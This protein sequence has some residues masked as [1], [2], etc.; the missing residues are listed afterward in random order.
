[1][2]LSLQW[3]SDFVA[4]REFDAHKI[5]ERLT[6]GTAEVEQIEQQGSLLAHCVVGKVLTVEKHPNADSLLLCDVKT[7]QGIKRIVCGGTNLEKDMLVAFAHVGA[8]VRWHGEAVQELKVT[9]IR[10]EKSEGMICAAEE[11]DLQ[12]LLPPKPEDGERPIVNL[13]RLLKEGEKSVGQ[14]LQKVLERTDTIFHINNTAITNR[15]DLFSHVGFARECVVLGLG[16]WKKKPE[17]IL[18]KFP[19]QKST[20]R[21]HADAPELAT[22]YLGCMLKVTGLGVTPDWMRMRLEAV[23][24][25]SLNLAVDITNYVAQE[26]G[27]PLHSFDADDIQGEVHMRL[28]RKGEIITTLD[29]VERKLPEGALILSDD[30]GVFDLLGIMGGLRSS[31]KE[32]T[33]NIFLHAASLN[34]AVIRRTVL[35]TGHRTDASTVYEKGVPPVVTSQG[36]ARA[37]GLFLE[38]LPGAEVASELESFG[39]DGTPKIITLSPKKVS[40]HLGQETSE[41]EISS[42]LETLGFIV[43][44]GKGEELE[45]STPLHRLGDIHESADLIE[46]VA[47]IAGLEGY[48]PELPLASITLPVRDHRL[49]LLRK[50]LKELGCTELVQLTFVGEN[51]LKQVGVPVKDL[52]AVQNPL[53]EDVK[54]IR[55]SLLPRLLEAANLNREHAE[56]T[57][58]LFEIGHVVLNGQEETE[59]TLLIVEKEKKGLTKEP[60]LH[61]KALL[62]E[63]AHALGV[64]LQFPREKT[65]DPKKHP[66]RNAEILYEKKHTGELFELHPVISK[67]FGFPARAAVATLS[68]DV[69]LQKK[70]QEKVYHAVPSFPSIVYDTTISVDDAVEVESLLKK[71]SG[72][73]PLLLDI[74]LVD[75]FQK[76]TKERKLTFRCTYNAPDRTLREDEVKPVHERV[77]QTLKSI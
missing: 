36:F 8:K 3:L 70:A 25:R 13:G 67:H 51:L 74:R 58:Q 68:P 44:R 41:E 26:V 22:R 9:K 38:L 19:S 71:T 30:K 72:M 64:A 77:E 63:L 75:L 1:M 60:F 45:V 7:E 28:S 65:S 48:S 56:A 76:G 62:R 21:I 73:H 10:G 40:A 42:P 53:G 4:F 59:L 27:V 52:A 66:A 18:P 39:S 69:L 43:K 17:W 50:T 11:L 5:A 57:L 33:K 23:G 12:S 15:P 47:R 20:I 55:P 32:S 31:T 2:K 46:E 14:P 6:L 16:T 49:T 35:A 37:L 24:L 61:A 54:Y 29:R 34:P